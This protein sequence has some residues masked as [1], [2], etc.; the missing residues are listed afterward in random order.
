MRTLGG[1]KVEDTQMKL[2]GQVGCVTRTNCFDFG[3]DLNPDPESR[4]FSPLR[5]GAKNDIQHNISKSYGWIPQKL[6]CLGVC[7]CLC[8]CLSV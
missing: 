2:G 8:E 5:D 4:I 3:E 7:V 1:Q 6:F